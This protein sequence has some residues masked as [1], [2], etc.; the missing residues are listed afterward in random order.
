VRYA[1]QKQLKVATA[2]RTLLDERLHEL[3][4]REGLSEVELWQR[5]QAWASWETL[6]RGKAETLELDEVL[7]E[8]DRPR[9]PSRRRRKP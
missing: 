2:A 6:K 1:A 5:A 7:K 9:R 4:E 3:E 8:F